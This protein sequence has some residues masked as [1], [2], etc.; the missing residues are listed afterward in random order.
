VRAPI[1]P[2]RGPLTDALLAHLQG[3]LADVLEVGDGIAP[4]GAGWPQ[5]PQTG[6]YTPYCV[7]GTEDAVLR[8]SPPDLAQ[9]MGSWAC[10][11]RLTHY[12]A[13][14]S[15]ADDNADMARQATLDFAGGTITLGEHSW[16]LTAVRYSR[17]GG[18]APVENEDPPVWSGRDVFAVWI[19][20]TRG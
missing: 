16:A 7:L 1:L 5:Q 15:Q 20:Y 18:F 2:V 6:D 10:G 13:A 4:P 3:S 12:G 14:R 17:L 11:Y 8:Q 9:A 19:D